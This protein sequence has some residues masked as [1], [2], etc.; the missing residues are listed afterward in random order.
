MQLPVLSH[1]YDIAPVLCIS[2]VLVLLTAVKPESTLRYRVTW[3]AVFCSALM[4]IEMLTAMRDGPIHENFP[5]LYQKTESLL[6]FWH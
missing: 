6:V 4:M 1:I 2:A 5:L 3:I